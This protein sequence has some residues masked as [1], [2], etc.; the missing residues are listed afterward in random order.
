MSS[1]TSIYA[2]PKCGNPN[3]RVESRPDGFC[4][5]PD[6]QHSWKTGESQPKPTVFQQITASPEVLAP[7]FVWHV[8]SFLD[9]P[10]KPKKIWYSTLINNQYFDTELEAKRATVAKLKEVENG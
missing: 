6:C 8:T 3:T 9:G 4:H 5:C 2:C 1:N 7:K 10:D